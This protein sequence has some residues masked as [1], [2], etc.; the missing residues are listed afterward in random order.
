M[1]TA[2]RVNYF[3]LEARSDAAAR[4]CLVQE[5]PLIAFYQSGQVWILGG[6]GRLLQGGNNGCGG[7]VEGEGRSR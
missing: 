6:I 2:Y 5:L 7:P 1:N 4:T 3:A